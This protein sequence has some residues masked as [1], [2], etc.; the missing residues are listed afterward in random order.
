MLPGTGSTPSAMT[1]AN[2]K[3]QAILELLHVVISAQIE[4]GKVILSIIQYDWDLVT[5][6][7]EERQQV[8]SLSE[9]S[10]FPAE[11]WFLR[12]SANAPEDFVS[13]IV[14]ESPES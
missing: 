3:V 12:L 7:D 10:E 5:Y 8:V 13:S 6:K 1:P 11:S 4:S 14:D 2:N 9:P